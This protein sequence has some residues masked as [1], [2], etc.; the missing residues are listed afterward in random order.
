MFW[1]LGL[2]VL[3]VVSI[4]IY[5][6]IVRKNTL[7]IEAWHGIDIELKRRYDLIPSLV[8]TVKGYTKHEKS[9]L[10]EIVKLRN[11]SQAITS[12]D[13]KS[14]I[15]SQISGAIKSIFALAESYPDLKSSEN[16]IQLHKSLEEV[17]SNILMARKYYNATVREYNTFITMFPV[18]FLAG[19]FNFMEKQFFSI[20]N[21]QERNNIKVELS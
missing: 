21:N 10:E 18:N 6:Q 4:T 15:E 8:E 14:K 9:T 2:G 16:F 3:V 1:L 5:N 12:V 11:S 7:A 17:E 13:E 19:K 20:D